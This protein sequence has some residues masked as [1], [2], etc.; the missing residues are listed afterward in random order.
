MNALADAENLKM[1]SA[2]I[3]LL[4]ESRHDKVKQSIDRLVGRGTIVQPPMGDEEEKDSV[5]RIRTRL[6][7]YMNKRDSV[8][9][10]AQLSP[11]FTAK[12]V[13]RWQELEAQI[14]KPSIPATYAAAL[15][16]AADQAEM[17][18]R[19]QIQIA[20]DAPK[21]EFV[22][23]YVESTGNIGFRMACKNLGA[24]EPDFRQFLIDQKIMYRLG[25][26][27]MPYSE[28]LDAGRFVV[29]A[30][31]ADVSGH[32]FNSARFTPKGFA[33]ISQLWN[34]QQGSE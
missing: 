16:I 7:Y 12:L 3:A 29:K 23:K 26:E 5:G 1:S 9:V 6:V 4:L 28:H 11:E 31:T 13:D 27:W 22:D 17:I 10:V 20:A 25:A 2:E 15:R 18:E 33:W 21:V 34:K 32:A 8:I 19:Q 14:A 30:G 24:K